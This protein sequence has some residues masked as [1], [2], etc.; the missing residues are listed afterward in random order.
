MRK[1]LYFSVNI[2]PVCAHNILAWL[3]VSWPQ[4][5][6]DQVTD[7]TTKPL[8]D[9][10]RCLVKFGRWL[11][12]MP[13]HGKGR[14]TPL[15][16]TR[17]TSIIV[18]PGLGLG[19]HGTNKRPR[20]K[21]AVRS[22]SFPNST[23]DH[24]HERPLCRSWRCANQGAVWAW[25]TG[26]R[27]G[28]GIQVRCSS[29]KCSTARWNNFQNRVDI[30]LVPTWTLIFKLPRQPNPALTITSFL[31][32]DRSPPANPHFWTTCLEQNLVLCPK[33]IGGRPQKGYGCRKTSAR[34][35]MEHRKW[36]TIF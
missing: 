28:Q 19:H 15:N 13:I 23:I 7:C 17:L 31:S 32:L 1:L 22:F 29:K 20:C 2:G 25:H 27:W 10:H 26:Y 3:H 11:N 6:K 16:V 14:H 24:D 18:P 34:G 12:Q 9:P 35:Q 36:P 5:A 33:L 8:S 4:V 30:V 21:K